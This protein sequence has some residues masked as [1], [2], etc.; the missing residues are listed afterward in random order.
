M[1][2]LSDY[3]SNQ[4]TKL[5]RLARRLLSDCVYGRSGFTSGD[6][7]RLYSLGVAVQ[8]SHVREEGL[9]ISIMEVSQGLPYTKEM[10]KADCQKA[11]IL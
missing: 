7:E 3:T 11:A 8:V 9:C 4:Q 10:F 1:N 6:A 5:R 2:T